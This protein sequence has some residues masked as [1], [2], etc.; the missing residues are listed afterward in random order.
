MVDQSFFI[1]TLPIIRIYIAKSQNKNQ[2]SKMACFSFYG[3]GKGRLKG[4]VSS[5]VE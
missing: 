2:A 5:F 3:K 1:S 4:V